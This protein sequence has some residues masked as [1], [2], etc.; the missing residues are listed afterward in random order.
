MAWAPI[1]QEGRRA[2]N[3][4]PLDALYDAAMEGWEIDPVINDD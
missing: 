1:E 3:E 4:D 2:M